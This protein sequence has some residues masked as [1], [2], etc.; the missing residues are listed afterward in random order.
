MRK[1]KFKIG[2]FI[3]LIIAMSVSICV[4]WNPGENSLSF[5]NIEALATSETDITSICTEATGICCVNGGIW[6]G[7][8]M[9]V[10]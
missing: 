3:S 6:Y 8:H 2:I 7:I 10:E 5:Q 4:S 1:N 9:K